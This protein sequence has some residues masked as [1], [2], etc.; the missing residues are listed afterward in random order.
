M[1]H[2]NQDLDNAQDTVNKLSNELLNG[3]SVT[4]LL[5][6]GLYSAYFPALFTLRNVLL[7]LFL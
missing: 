5:L 3:N 7:L 4:L 6:R 2:V 1:W